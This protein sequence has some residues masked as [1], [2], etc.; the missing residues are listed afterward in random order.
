MKTGRKR[1]VCLF[2]VAC[3]LWGMVGVLPAAAAGEAVSETTS[4]EEATIRLSSYQ[5]TY[6]GTS[7]IPGVE[8]FVGMIELTKNQDYEV[9]YSNNVEVGTATVTATGIGRYT[10]TVQ[11]T[12]K[13]IPRKISATCFLF[14][15]GVTC[16]KPYDGTR[17]GILNVKV[18]LPT[19]EVTTSI[20]ATYEDQYRGDRK[21]VSVKKE[22]IKEKTMR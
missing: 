16:M 8:V 14:N 13:I 3:V 22:D 18:S 5:Y 10:G 7:K 6:S 21:K 11:T 1:G 9:K 19:G 2:L 12:F 15:E 4:L 17:D 20:K